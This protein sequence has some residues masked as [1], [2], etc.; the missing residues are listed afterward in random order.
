[1]AHFFH[2]VLL[3]TDAS[4]TITLP[5]VGSGDPDGVFFCAKTGGLEGNK[6]TM[7]MKIGWFSTSLWWWFFSKIFYVTPLL[8][9]ET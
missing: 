9:G 1:M 6:K 7:C 5:E 3:Q 4:F 8:L 2:R